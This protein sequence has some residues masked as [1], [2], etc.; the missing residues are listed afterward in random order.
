MGRLPDTDP[1]STSIDE[2]PVGLVLAAD[3]VAGEVV[4]PFDNSAV[5]GY[6]VRAVDLVDA[7]AELVVVGEIAAGAA[8]VDRSVPARRSA[9]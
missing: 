6:A 2:R 5:D 3:V 8:A 7:P 9:S 1:R 4:P